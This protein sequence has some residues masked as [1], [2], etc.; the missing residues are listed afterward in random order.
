MR[1]LLAR[2][3]LYDSAQIALQAVSFVKKS[4]QEYLC[5]LEYLFYFSFNEYST[6]P[7]LLALP[8]PSQK[9]RCNEQK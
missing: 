7:I 3:Q 9:E 8:S 1:R 2:D 5:I 6:G 4:T